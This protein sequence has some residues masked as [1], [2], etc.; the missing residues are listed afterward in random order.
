MNVR[1]QLIEFHTAMGQPI[2][3]HPTVPSYERIRLRAE[4]V[5]EEAFE[6]LLS[7]FGDSDEQVM[8]RIAVR[9]L[10]AREKPSVDMVGLADA[11]ADIDYVVEGTRLEF[12]IDGRPIADEVH[13]SNMA[14]V[15]GPV[16]A[17]GKRMKPEG[18]TP[19]DIVGELRKQGLL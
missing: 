17:D 6:F 10:I 14:K 7:C 11:L 4:L 9:E 1:D 18:W 19:P 2:L 16:R 3:D 5:M 8:I 15:G 13:R 12:G